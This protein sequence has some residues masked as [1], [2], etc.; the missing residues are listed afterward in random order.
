MITTLQKNQYLINTNF[1]IIF[2]SYETIMFTYYKHDKKIVFNTDGDNYTKTT[3]KYL[4]KA[5]CKLDELTKFKHIEI[6]DLCLK[7]NNR[8]KDILALKDGILNLC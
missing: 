8:K 4:V 3:C 1:E 6:N 7:S 2:Q 5:L